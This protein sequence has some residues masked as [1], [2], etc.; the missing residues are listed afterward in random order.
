MPW[1]PAPILARG[2][3]ACNNPGSCSGLDACTF[4]GGPGKATIAVNSCIGDNSCFAAGFFSSSKIG[5]GSCSIGDEPCYETGYI[6]ISSNR[7]RLLQ[8]R[9]CLLHNGHQFR[10]LSR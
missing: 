6:G 8:R 4:A 5:T 9:R 7:R 3:L 10:H 1:Q 2:G